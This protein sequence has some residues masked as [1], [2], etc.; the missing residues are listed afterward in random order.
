MQTNHSVTTYACKQY[1]EHLAKAAT[2]QASKHFKVR[3]CRACHCVCVYCNYC[4][5]RKARACT[6]S[7]SSDLPFACTSSGL[8]FFLEGVLPV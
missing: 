3:K 6:A 4:V 8:P 1:L 7:P 5:K 2:P